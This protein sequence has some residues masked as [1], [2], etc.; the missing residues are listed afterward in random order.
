[1]GTEI[2]DIERG[3]PT[4]RREDAGDHTPTIAPLSSRSLERLKEASGFL[5]EAERFAYHALHHGCS[6][7]IARARVSAQRG[8][9]LLELAEGNRP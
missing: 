5:R 2:S 6:D 3:L 8:A 7:A 4:V 9:D 1:M